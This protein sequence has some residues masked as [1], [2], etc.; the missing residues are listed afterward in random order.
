MLDQRHGV[1]VKRLC[2]C[3]LSSLTFERSGV[4]HCTYLLSLSIVLAA[5]FAAPQT[6]FETPRA[7]VYL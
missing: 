4:D 7:W 1:S 5:L 2:P 3:L 6:H